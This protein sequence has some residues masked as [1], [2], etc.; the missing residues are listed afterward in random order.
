MQQEQKRCNA[1]LFQK[2]SFSSLLQRDSLIK[3][4]GAADAADNKNRINL[5]PLEAKVWR[6]EKSPKEESPT[7]PPNC[8]PNL[9]P[10][11]RAVFF[12]IIHPHPP[13]PPLIER[14]TASEY[15]NY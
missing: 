14:D 11:T 10:L 2:S 9:T 6:Y 7:S 3:L 5:F 4:S 15:L 13:Y 12:F 1:I 8:R